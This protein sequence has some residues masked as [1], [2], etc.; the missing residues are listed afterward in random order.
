MADVWL[1]FHASR[2]T[3]HA[4]RSDVARI[5]TAREGRILGAANNAAGVAEDCD[6]VTVD[7]KAQQKVIVIYITCG[8]E[9]LG[10]LREVQ[11]PGART[12]DLHGVAPTQGRRHLAARAFQELELA[13]A[14]RRASGALAVAGKLQPVDLQIPNI[15]A[16]QRAVQVVAPAG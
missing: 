11:A 16:N 2:I 10:Q 6:V 12:P 15:Y 4:S 13:L 14:A 7:A 1:T 8:L 3:F 9:A 5:Q